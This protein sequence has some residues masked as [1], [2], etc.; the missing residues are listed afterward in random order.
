MIAAISATNSP[1]R[2]ERLLPSLAVI[3]P[4]GGAGSETGAALLMAR[5]CLLQRSMGRQ[6]H[7]N[8]FV[9]SEVETLRAGV[10]TTLD[11]NGQ[12]F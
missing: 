10:S 2:S 11:T 6:F 9:S 12:G 4:T 8:P 1:R 5:Q 3:V 7:L